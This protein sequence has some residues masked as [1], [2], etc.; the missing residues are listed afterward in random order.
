[1]SGWFQPRITE[2]EKQ[3][4][5]VLEFA[6]KSVEKR[7]E[8]VLSVHPDA[9]INVTST[10]NSVEFT[11]WDSTGNKKIAREFYLV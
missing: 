3:K 11:A 5:I 9:G 8:A 7:R 1:M 4:T 2:A 10:R 6:L